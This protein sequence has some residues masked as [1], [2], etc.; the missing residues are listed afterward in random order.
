MSDKDSE[1]K[2]LMESIGE[3]VTGIF[4]VFATIAFAGFEW[5]LIWD[6]FAAPVFQA[7]N[8][9]VPKEIGYPTA[10][11]IA[12]CLSCARGWSKPNEKKEKFGEKIKWWLEQIFLNLIY[13][14]FLWIL[15]LIL[16]L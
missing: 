7:L 10:V 9:C 14:G 5:W 11:A 6:W 15:H 4:V 12:V 1:D 16:P 8:M 3:L 2:N 13:L